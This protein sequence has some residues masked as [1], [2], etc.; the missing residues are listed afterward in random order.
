MGPAVRTPVASRFNARAVLADLEARGIERA[1]L[2]GHSYGGGATLS[3]AQLAPERVEALVLLASVGTRLLDR[4]GRAGRAGGRGGLRAR[5]VV[6]DSVGG[7]RQAG[8]HRLA[9]AAAYRRG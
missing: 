7:A 8:S 2:V 9:P 6:A 4:L 1:V 5:R 3:V